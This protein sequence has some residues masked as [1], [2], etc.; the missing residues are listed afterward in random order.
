MVKRYDRR[1]TVRFDTS[2]HSK[3]DR[4]LEN[5]SYC[6]N[7]GFNRSDLLRKFVDSSI[8]NYER[9]IGEI[10]HNEE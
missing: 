8:S 3:L 5:D 2:T 7:N 10:K 9:N 4:L 6:L 1:V